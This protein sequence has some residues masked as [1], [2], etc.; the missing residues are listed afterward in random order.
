[1]NS[2]NTTE[3]LAENLTRFAFCSVTC[4]LFKNSLIQEKNIRFN[5]GITQCEDALFVFDYLS[6]YHCSVRTKSECN[7]HYRRTSKARGIYRCFP[8]EESYL[9]MKL[10]SERLAAIRDIYQCPNTAYLQH[11]M[12]CSQIYN[13]YRTIKEKKYSTFRKVSEYIR[14]LR[15]EYVRNILMEK[16]FIEKR[17]NGLA[18]Y[19]L[20]RILYIFLD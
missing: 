9:L 20:M 11:E 19:Y 12:L 4:K 3:A 7:Y 10:L 14:L 18:L 6:A 2:Y 1:M 17:R 5:E 16:N 8:M 13:I 15:N